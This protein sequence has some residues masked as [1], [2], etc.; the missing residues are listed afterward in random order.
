MSSQGTLMNQ[1]KRMTL[2]SQIRCENSTPFSILHFN[3]LY[4]PLSARMPATW[5]LY[6]EFSRKSIQCI[7]GFTQSQTSGWGASCLL[8]SGRIGVCKASGRVLS[9]HSSRAASK[10][11]FISVYWPLQNRR[12]CHFCAPLEPLC[13][14]HVMLGSLVATWLSKIR[15][16]PSRLCLGQGPNQRE[17]GQGPTSSLHFSS[18]LILQR[19]SKSWERLQVMRTKMHENSLR[20]MV[21]SREDEGGGC[22]GVV[23]GREQRERKQQTLACSARF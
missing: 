3:F 4:S 20:A 8:A 17:S 18:I 9:H 5:S 21:S 22:C 6:F 19:C 16:T 10:T 1:C 14:F 13:P 7:R 15:A 23:Q 2:S 12:L 11:V